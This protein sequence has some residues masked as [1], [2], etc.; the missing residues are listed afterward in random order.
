[1]SKNLPNF[2][3]RGDELRATDYNSVIS[4]IRSNKFSP[5][6]GPAVMAGLAQ[7]QSKPFEV[8]TIGSKRDDEEDDGIYFRLRPGYII[9][10]D[11][12]FNVYYEVEGSGF[13]PLAN[14][15]IFKLNESEGAS[16]IWLAVDH[17]TYK[18]FWA[19]EDDFN[20]RVSYITRF[21]IETEGENKNIIYEDLHPQN[22]VK[23]TNEPFKVTVW[24]NHASLES[25]NDPLNCDVTIAPGFVWNLLPS[26]DEDKPLDRRSVSNAADPAVYLDATETPLFANLEENQLIYVKVSTDGKNKI[27][28]DPEIFLTFVDVEDP[29]KY[30]ESTHYQPNP[31]SVNGVY[32]YPLAK[33]KKLEFVNDVLGTYYQYVA[34]QL[35]TGDLMIQPNLIEIENVGGK[36]EWYKT[37]RIADSVYEFRTAEQLEGRGET[38]IK[39]LSG[40]TAG[41]SEAVPPIPATAAESE[42]DTIKWKRI[43]E[44]VSSPQVRVTTEDEGAVVQIRGN[45]QTDSFTNVQKFSI[46]YDDGLITSFTPIDTPALSGGN[47]NLTITTWSEDTI[48]GVSTE[49]SS[50]VLYWRNGLFIGIVDPV[51]APAVLIEKEVTNLVTA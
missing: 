22:I 18:F 40:A 2:A 34:E 11:D 24:Q 43:A 20:S 28:D 39:A 10:G 44:R 46:S 21:R 12:Y 13:E 4:E 1:M 19:T 37:L 45:D 8:V 36:R 23:E 6:A 33:I 15:P 31:V 32:Y 35:W 27:T 9:D 30:E 17:D 49:G 50:E 5:S 26:A 51:D 42:G 48:T 14:N 47:L 7:R 29:T 3:K 41:D 38:I 16:S 25:D